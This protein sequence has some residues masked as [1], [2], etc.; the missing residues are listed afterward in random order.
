MLVKHC[1]LCGR[2]I[3]VSLPYSSDY[4][5]Y[6]PQRK[7]YHAD[8]F[9]VVTTPR[10]LKGD[11]FA[12]TKEYVL[13]EVSKDDLY[14]YFVSHYQA[15]NVPKRVFI[16]LDSIYKGTAKGLAQPIPPHELLDMLE[17]KESYID[18][19]FIK[20]NITDSTT[21][22]NYALTTVCGSYNSYKEWKAGLEAERI[23]SEHSAKDRQGYSYKLRG[24]TPPS[25][26]EPENNFIDLDEEE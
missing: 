6:K 24:Y 15:S 10:V 5:Y 4:V 2:E 16:R 18:K 17:R 13:Q 25:Q 22:I 8:C 20:K 1:A 7:W 26:P 3:Q 19:Q 11:W 21:K 12:K 23:A 9:T 14:N